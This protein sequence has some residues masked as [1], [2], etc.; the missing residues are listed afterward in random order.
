MSYVENQPTDIGAYDVESF[1]GGGTSF[2][3]KRAS[4]VISLEADRQAVKTKYPK[5]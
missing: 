2:T 1:N 3:L 5:P 4:A